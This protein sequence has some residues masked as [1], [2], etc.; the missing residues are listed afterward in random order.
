MNRL[1]A[2]G[3]FELLSIDPTLLTK[4][5]RRRLRGKLFHGYR[6]L[7]RIDIPKGRQR[8]HLVQTLHNA[9]RTAGYGLAYCFDPRHA[10]RASV[11]AQTIDLVICFECY[12]ILVHLPDRSAETQP[13]RFISTSDSAQPAFDAA[14]KKAGIPLANRP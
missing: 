13:A 1:L 12:K 2:E 5:Q 14:L 3:E 6:V 7:G 10:I 11:G 8:D 4:K 9:L